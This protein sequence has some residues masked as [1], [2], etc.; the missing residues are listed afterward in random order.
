MALSLPN[1]APQPILPQYVD[2]VYGEDQQQSFHPVTLWSHNFTQ[3]N[4]GKSMTQQQGQNVQDP[5]E[6]R[7][8]PNQAPPL[9]MPKTH[10]WEVVPNSTQRWEDRQARAS[11]EK[12]KHPMHICLLSCLAK[13]VSTW[14]THTGTNLCNP[15]R[16]CSNSADSPRGRRTAE[17]YLRR[18][19][20]LQSRHA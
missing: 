12:Q 19:D 16:A 4:G 6:R 14:W 5:P 10:A 9:M 17:T 18:M 20:T 15:A 2:R 13:V 11:K 7:E 8:Q 1:W 3:N